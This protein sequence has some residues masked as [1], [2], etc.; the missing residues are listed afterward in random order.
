MADVGLLGAYL[1]VTEQHRIPT[2]FVSNDS[3]AMRRRADENWRRHF[4]GRES[5]WSRVFVRLRLNSERNN[6]LKKKFSADIR[7]RGIS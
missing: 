5:P 3:D 4:D 6:E 1:A 7:P 2:L